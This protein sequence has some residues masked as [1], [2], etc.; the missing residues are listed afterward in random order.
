M[1]WFIL[2][3]FIVTSSANAH[4]SNAEP[5]NMYRVPECSPVLKEI[6]IFEIFSR[7]T[8][9]SDTAKSTVTLVGKDTWATA[10]HSVID[11]TADDITIY[12]PGITETKATIRWVDVGK[13]LAILSADSGDIK[14][15]KSLTGNIGKFEQVWT[16]GYPGFAAELMSFTGTFVR[17]DKANFAVA[18]AIAFNGMSGGALAR[19]HE[20]ELEVFGIITNLIQHKF[21]HVQFIQNGIL[22]DFK[23]VTNSGVS[24]S[25]P[26]LLKK[27]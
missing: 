18:N 7:N 17:Y 21:A 1:K 24:L 10:A 3:I 11:G 14:P 12:T 8:E 4:E 26:I 6:P 22:H 27:D 5:S 15:M 9:T 13:D 2:L 23:K 25:T 20:G 19:C 16:I